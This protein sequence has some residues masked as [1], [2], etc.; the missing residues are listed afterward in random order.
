MAERA[1]YLRA[2]YSIKSPDALQLASAIEA[3]C[4]AFLTHDFG[5]RRITDIKILIVGEIELDADKQEPDKNSN[6]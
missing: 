4:E 1:A 6:A 2:K 3:G 5:L